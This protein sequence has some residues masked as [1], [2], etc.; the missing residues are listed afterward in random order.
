M[1]AT[2]T[3]VALFSGGKDSS[4]ALYRALERDLPVDRL[5]TVHPPRD[6]YMYH[7]PATDLAGLAA[8]S[9][10]LPLEELELAA[11][12]PG[13]D[14]TTAPVQADTRPDD[15]DSFSTDQPTTPDSTT[16]GDAE[17]E[18][19]RERLAAL[20]TELAGGLAGI[21]AGAVESEFQTSRL[22]RVAAALEID[23]FAPL[24]RADP[25]TLAEE[26]LEAGFEIVVVQVAAGGLDESWLG[27]TLD[28]AAFDELAEL[29]ET[30]GVHLL[31]EGGEYETIVTDGPHMAR[32]IR[33]EHEREWA[34]NR[35][36][37]RITD[38]WLA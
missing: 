28:R 12:A 15:P 20:D 4:L 22:E 9:I 14:S 34:G 32:P 2:G 21:V 13:T 1:T 8:E 23:C 27:R 16:R 30:H 7:V 36:R 38:A 37:L 11:Q 10:G 6:S 33:L 24:W 17:V 19:L 35:G 26:L 31:G 3:W 29:G 25:E 18:P 5:L